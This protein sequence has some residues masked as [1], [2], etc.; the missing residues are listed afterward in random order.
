MLVKFD[1]VKKIECNQ[2]NLD[3][4]K[5]LHCVYKDRYG[6]IKELQD[7]IFKVTHNYLNN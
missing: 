2:L 4:E 5:T 6:G 1:K 3:F 7:E